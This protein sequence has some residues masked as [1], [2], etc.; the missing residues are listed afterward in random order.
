MNE[1]HPRRAQRN[2]G[3]AQTTHATSTRSATLPIRKLVALLCTLAVAV[4]MAIVGAPPAL[5]DSAP[6][7][8]TNPATPTTVTAD[9]LPTVQ[10]DG[11]AWSQ[12]V[13]GNTVYVA[14][15]FNNARPYGAPE[16]VNETPRRNILAYDIRTGELIQ[17]FNPVLNGPAFAIAAS[18]DGSRIYVGGS[19]TSHNGATVWRLVALNPVTGAL[20]LNFLPQVGG[21][22][23]ALAVAGNTVYAGGLFGS[24][25]TATRGRLAAINATNGALLPWAPVAE[26]GRV[27]SIAAT[28]DGSK[29]MVG[30]MFPTLNG[31]SSPGYGLGAL[32]GIT[33]ELLPLPVNEVVRNAGERGSITSLSSDGE[34]V[35][36][37]GYTFARTETLEG[38]FSVKWSDLSTNWIADCHG[39]SYSIY[40]IGDLVYVASHAHYCGNMGGFPQETNWE[41]WR[42]LAFSKE[43]TGVI[44]KEPFTYT[45]FEGNPR[46]ELQNWFPYLNAGDFTGQNQGPWSV[47]GN[48]DYVVMG[49][50]FPVVN[51]QPQQGLT[52]FAV[53]EIAPNARGPRIS[54]ANFMPTVTSLEAGSVRVRW[55]ANWDQDNK[56]LTYQVLRNGVPIHTTSLESTFWDRPGMTFVDTNRVPGQEY[57]YRIFATDPF[58]NEV[59]GDTVTY[60]VP[61]SPPAESA[62]ADTV[63]GDGARNHWRLGE[64]SGPTGFDSVGA[65]DLNIRSGMTLGTAGAI[66]GDTNTGASLNGTTLG[67]ATNPTREMNPNDFTVETWI[68]T[69]TTTGGRILGFG[70]AMTAT[71]VDADRH[72]YMDNA[73]KIWF[74]AQPALNSR[75]GINSLNSYND[76]QWHHLA[77]TLGDGGMALYVDG[78]LVGQRTDV[79][80]GRNIGGYWRIGGDRLNSWACRPSNQNFTGDID[81]VAIYDGALTEEQIRDHVVAAEQPVDTSAAGYGEAVQASGP[82]NYWRLGESAGNSALDSSSNCVAGTYYNAVT[83]GVPGAING[84]TDTGAT[85]NGVNAGTA[86][87]TR[88]T[89]PTEYSTELWFNTTTEAGGQLVGFGE[90]RSGTSARNDRHV[91]METDGR[92][93]FAVNPGTPTAVTTTGT[94]NDGQWHHLVATQGADGMRLYVDGAEVGSDPQTGS[95]NHRGYWRLGGD[96]VGGTPRYFAGTIDEAA[97]YSSAISAATVTQHYQLGTTGEA[98][99]LAPTAAFDATAEALEVA[100]DATGSA[101]PDGTI[102]SY[103]WDFGDDQVGS[104]S[105]TSHSYAEAGSYEVTL[106]VTDDDG[107]TDTVTEEVVVE[108]PANVLPVASFEQ[109][110]NGLTVN[111]DGTGSSDTDGTVV[112]YAWDFGD[113]ITSDVAVSSHTYAAEGTYEVTLTVT[114][115]DGG[116]HTVAETVTVST[117]PVANGAP[118][119]AFTSSVEG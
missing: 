117:P 46:P 57:R 13:V 95:S 18:P 106:T 97:V 119:A 65:D 29:V 113:G 24:V 47:S 79:T 64:P 41:Y 12:V 53:N 30:G 21:T 52:R 83:R 77:A 55:Q 69:T 109:D 49:G 104:G 67:S 86:G 72:L 112:S 115:N 63:D 88:I 108:A 110:T 66:T 39:D 27:D 87:A 34:N 15:E 26:G 51:N 84:S 19:F 105:T 40:P 3:T 81:E 54:G 61:E 20:D 89:N 80:N 38:A 96:A 45:N 82:L 33:G 1:H 5:A 100:F 48:D 31:S 114:D 93:T 28:A 92:L 9:A 2:R 35:Y 107:A 118:V 73:G 25:G 22:V 91:M 90:S 6:L 58:G 78:K 60:T 71:S 101:D 10:M 14:G 17:S 98:A 68:R 111:V 36:G 32:D 85:F 99:N 42:A 37:T 74:G 103:T 16:G 44:T 70:E 62:Y 59:R 102:D 23:R 75:V 43:A 76:G 50:E 7:D 11:V 94:Y 4:S 8:P 56:N 116:T